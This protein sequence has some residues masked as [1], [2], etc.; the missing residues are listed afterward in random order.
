MGSLIIFISNLVSRGFVS[1]Q[2]RFPIRSL[3]KT[4]LY[5]VL[6]RQLIRF[7]SEFRRCTDVFSW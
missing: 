6:M 7:L 5:G 4:C 2:S 1:I 3:L